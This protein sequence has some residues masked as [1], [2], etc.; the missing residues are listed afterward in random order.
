MGKVSKV[1]PKC[2]GKNW[3]LHGASYKGQ[4]HEHMLPSHPA[5][6]LS[7]DTPLAPNIFVSKYP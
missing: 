4:H 5:L 7:F 6:L 2:D 3:V 1:F